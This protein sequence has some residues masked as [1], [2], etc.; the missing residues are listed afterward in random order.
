MQPA[1]FAHS[2]LPTAPCPLIAN[3]H[4][5]GNVFCL[6][7]VCR[8]TAQKAQCTKP[9]TS[10]AAS[11]AFVARSNFATTGEIAARLRKL[12]VK[13]SLNSV[14]SQRANYNSTVRA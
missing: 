13:A 4:V 8:I 14:C 5:V 6:G 10:D 9:L 12:A 7:K 3:S 11:T 2:P 1:G